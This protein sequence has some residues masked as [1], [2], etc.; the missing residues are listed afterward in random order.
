MSIFYSN[1]IFSLFNNIIS[2]NNKNNNIHTDLNITISNKY[3]LFFF[4]DSDIYSN[5]FN[6]LMDIDD[7]FKDKFSNT[8][9]IVFDKEQFININLSNFNIISLNNIFDNF[10]NIV[11][12]S[13]AEIIIYIDL[14]HFIDFIQ[15]SDIETH[16][17]DF[18]IHK[19]KSKA[20]RLYIFENPLINLDI[21]KTLFVKEIFS[22]QKNY[23]FINNNHNNIFIFKLNNVNIKYWNIYNTSTNI[24]NLSDN[25][26]INSSI[27][28]FSDFNN[29][30][31]LFTCIPISDISLNNI[32]SHHFNFVIHPIDKLKIFI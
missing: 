23:K 2:H 6:F 11:S 5:I 27:K 24:F 3:Y 26:Y 17:F 21:K 20:D 12:E 22:I 7:N 19:L 8:L 1:N 29:N 31:F 25:D 10:I 18:I 30:E 4:S 15:N 13:N 28:I 9:D 14:K 16:V 32:I